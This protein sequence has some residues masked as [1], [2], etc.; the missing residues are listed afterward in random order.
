MR[1]VMCAH[2]GRGRAGLPINMVVLALNAE[3][4]EGACSGAIPCRRR[5]WLFIEE[6]W[7]AGWQR[8]FG[9]PEMLR[10]KGSLAQVGDN[11]CE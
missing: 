9:G 8:A 5:A 6:P 3:G 10:R 1:A 11:D 2:T 7:L 4:E